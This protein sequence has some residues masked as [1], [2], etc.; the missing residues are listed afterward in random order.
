MRSKVMCWWW[1]EAATAC[2]TDV[3]C[4]LEW[5]RLL[6]ARG[7]GLNKGRLGNGVDGG[8]C[9]YVGRTLHSATGL[10]SALAV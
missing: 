7:H 5:R 3:H 6:L 2:P 9:V 1:L 10:A 8:R 4:L